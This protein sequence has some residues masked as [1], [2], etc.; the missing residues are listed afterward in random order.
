M[1]QELE[2][3]GLVFSV[4]TYIILEPINVF[5]KKIV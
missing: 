1:I 4:F 3:E 2:I 5:Y